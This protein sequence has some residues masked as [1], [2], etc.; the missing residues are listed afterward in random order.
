MPSSPRAVI[1]DLDGTL[2]DTA[3]LHLQAWLLLSAEVGLPFTHQDF[4]DTFGWRN[5]EIVPKVF[6]PT[7]GPEKI[8]RIGARKEELYRAEA[9]RGVAL[10]PGAATLLRDLHAAGFR[11]AIGSSAP[12][13][14]IELLLDVSG[15]RD[16][17][18][19]YAGAEDTTRGK[20][21]PEV[22]LTAAGKLGVPPA[23]CVVIEDAP[24][25]V[26]AAKAGAMKAVG[27]TFAG[28]HPAESLRRAGAD[29]V[30]PSLEQLQVAA[31]ESLVGEE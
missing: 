16:L 29:L 20:P 6:G 18:S 8:A 11:Q 26:Q 30:I 14:N 22:F 15:I 4:T 31:I 7:F 27:V 19:T 3:Q 5:A 1:W 10:L 17:L 12:R 9:R 21:D 2:V 28:H 25:G 23:R 24:V 13:A